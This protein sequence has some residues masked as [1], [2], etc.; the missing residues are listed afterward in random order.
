MLD[1]AT[2]GSTRLVVVGATGWMVSELVQSLKTNS[3]I[4]VLGQVSDSAL[5]ELMQGTK[6][7]V[8]P[9]LYEGFGLPVVE[10]MARGIPVLTGDTGATGEIAEGAAILVDPTN[11]D[12][13]HDG[14]VRLLTE[15]ELLS[16]LSLQGRE[17]AKSFSW[18]RTAQVT[19]ETLEVLKRA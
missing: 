17:R 13:I 6:A 10:A 19:L 18:E 1:D 2:R 8:Y 5:A 12:A 7:L 16:F 3:T 9:S 15:P 14:L 4:D 11:V